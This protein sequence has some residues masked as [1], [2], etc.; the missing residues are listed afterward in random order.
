MLGELPTEPF[1]P[2]APLDPDPLLPPVPLPPETPLAAAPGLTVAA[3]EPALGVVVEGAPDAV[4]GAELVPATALVD[5]E[6]LVA[7]AGD[8]TAAFLP[9]PP[10]AANA[11]MTAMHNRIRRTQLPPHRTNR[12]EA[13]WE[14]DATAYPYRQN[15]AVD[16]DALRRRWH[17]LLDP[18]GAP[19][20]YVA[21]AFED[22]V[23]RYAE[24]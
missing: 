11:A 15:E 4:A 19:R 1:E 12:V 18:F 20:A 9:P 14:P 16:G 23:R 8:F 13:S 10:H 21:D 6:S 24:D 3:E 7:L 5:V 2:A 22:I 17:H